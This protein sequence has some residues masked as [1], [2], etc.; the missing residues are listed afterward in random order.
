MTKVLGKLQLF[1]SD[2]VASL[3]NSRVASPH[4]TLTFFFRPILKS[5]LENFFFFKQ[6][7][8]CEVCFHCRNKLFAASLRGLFLNGILNLF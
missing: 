5:G 2:R 7:E 8:S 3:P 4:H 1:A 6:T